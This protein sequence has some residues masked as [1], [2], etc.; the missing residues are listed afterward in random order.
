MRTVGK[1]FTFVLL[2][3]CV[4]QLSAEDRIL[5][6]V[7]GDT[8]Q[9]SAEWLPPP[10]KPTLLLRIHGVDTPE[11]GA[12]SECPEEARKA[13]EA[14]MFTS[15]MVSTAVIKEI[16]LYSWDKYGGRVLGDV[17]LDGKSLKQMLLDNG[18]ARAYS[19]EAK[20]SWCK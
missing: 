3:L 20:K 8:L 6:V 12:R 9:V 10:L 14:T 17:I 15:E 16:K 1:F 11:K 18:H 5:R 4:G 7:D 13:T 19:G 2:S